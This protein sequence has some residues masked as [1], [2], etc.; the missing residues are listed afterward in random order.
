MGVWVHRPSGDFDSFVAALAADAEFDPPLPRRHP[1]GYPLFRVEVDGFVF[2]F[3]S[4]A[5][6]RTCIA[7]FEARILPRTRADD[8]RWSNRHWVS[9]LPARVKSWRYRAKAAAYLRRALAAFEEDG[10]GR[11]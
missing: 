10:V 7:A 6:M 8:G 2:E 9:R 11:A 3:A 5:E 1:Q 4:L